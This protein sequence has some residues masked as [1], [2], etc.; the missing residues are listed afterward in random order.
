VLLILQDVG[1]YCIVTNPKCGVLELNIEGVGINYDG[2]EME[3]VDFTPIQD[4]LTPMSIQ[5]AHL[6]LSSRH[7]YLLCIWIY[8]QFTLL[9]IKLITL[10]ETT[11]I[12]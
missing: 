12:T 7:F 3:L 1:L 11:T 10:T 9:L 8:T 4:S 2:I 6:L 5:D